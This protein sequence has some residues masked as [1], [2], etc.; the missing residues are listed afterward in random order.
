[1]AWKTLDEMDLAGKVVLVRVDINVPVE[2]GVVTDATRIEKIAP[3]VKDILAKGGKPVLLA[4]FGRP[5]GKPVPEMSL[6]PLVPELA[7]AL[8]VP[9]KFAEDCIGAP[10]KTAVAA[11]AAGEV[12]L[13]ENTRFHAGE[14]KNDPELSAAMAA[15]GEVYVNDAFSAAHRAHSSTE[16]VAHILPAVA[17]RLM[18]AELKAL[19]AALGNPVRPVCA[20]VGGAK[21][22]TK[23]DLLGNL[24]TKV[25]H[26]VIG[27]GMANTFLVAQGI[28]VGKSLAEREMAE[29]AREILEKA[30]AA[31]CAIHLPAD[32]V[33]AREFKAG[34]ENE[35][36]GNADCPAD[37]MILDA[38][39]KSVEEIAKVFEASKTLIWNGPLGAFEIAPFDAATNA[40][41]QKAADLTKAGKL[42]SVAGGGD[43]VAA[44]N[45]AGAA[46]DFSYI[47]TAGGAF[48]EWMEGKELPGVAAL[49]K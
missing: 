2:N 10:A 43:T 30:A 34:A 48:L 5:K 27:G 6:R 20:V 35:V 24:V 3:T 12:L 18:A 46:E 23:L 26:L 14:E 29:T 40:A 8:G 13:L 37:A 31:G 4:H 39:P 28:D 36:V 1:M 47:S 17:G 45:K 16:G 15:L 19:E 44:L 25:D 42:V 9:V 41:A 32:V 7:K 21:V 38:G 22:S 33:V 11:L 49:M